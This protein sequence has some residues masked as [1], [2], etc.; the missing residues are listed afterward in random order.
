MDELDDNYRLG[1]EAARA[2]RN[3]DAV[4]L[5]EPVVASESVDFARREHARM[6][7]GYAHAQDGRWEDAIPC[8]RAAMLNDIECLPAR[9]ALGHALLQSGRVDEAIEVYRTAAQLAPSSAPARHGLGWALMQKGEDL[10]EA[11]YQAQEALRLDPGSAAIRDSVGWILY[12][13]GDAEAAAEQLELAVSID[14]DH[15]VILAHRR[16]VREALKKEGKA[17]S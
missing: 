5:L 17:S 11:L 3:A 13:L 4:R 8:F 15:P 14:P 16:E 1:I 6:L 12:K 2:G 7:L 9:T 10:D